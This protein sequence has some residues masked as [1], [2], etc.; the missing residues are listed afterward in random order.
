MRKKKKG[1]AAR[2]WGFIF[3]GW[4]I[5]DPGMVLTHKETGSNVFGSLGI[6]L[7]SPKPNSGK[8]NK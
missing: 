4:G 5:R 2:V 3:P 7:F 1:V 8:K 6:C